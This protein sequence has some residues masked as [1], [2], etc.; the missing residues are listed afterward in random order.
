MHA[1]AFRVMRLSQPE[2]PAEQT[3]SLDV[4]LD[5]LTDAQASTSAPSTID[6]SSSCLTPDVPTNMTQKA[7]R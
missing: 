7:S 5:M 2:L 6:V 3:L 4:A 1:L